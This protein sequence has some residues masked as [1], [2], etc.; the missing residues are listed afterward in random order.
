MQQARPLW[1]ARREP[2]ATAGACVHACGDM[3]PCKAPRPW[4][5]AAST[6][7]GRQVNAVLAGSMLRPRR[8]ARGTKAC[9]QHALS[10]ER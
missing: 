6:H 3:P 10:A 8:P 2:H 5:S 9:A 4:Q 1:D 7:A